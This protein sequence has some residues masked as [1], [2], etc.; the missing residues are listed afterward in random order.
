MR[1]MTAWLLALVL[2]AACVPAMAETRID[3][4]YSRFGV[5]DEYQNLGIGKSIM[6]V[7]D[8]E[9]FHDRLDPQDPERILHGIG[10]RTGAAIL[11]IRTGDAYIEGTGQKFFSAKIVHL[12]ASQRVVFDKEGGAPAGASSLS[13]GPY[14]FYFPVVG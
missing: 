5:S 11:Q 14:I 8:A 7:F 10:T 2:L 1:R 3:L 4:N 13:V 6:A 12:S 9:A